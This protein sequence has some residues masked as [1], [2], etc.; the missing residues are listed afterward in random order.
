[1][2]KKV[3]IE[4]WDGK[5][6]FDPCS[7]YMY[8]QDW[9]EG[10]MLVEHKKGT[11]KDER[12]QHAWE[13]ESWTYQNNLK[14]VAKLEKLQKNI[15][16]I[17]PTHRGHRPWMK[18]CLES[19]AALGYFVILCYDNPYKLPGMDWASRMPSPDAMYAADMVLMKHVTWHAGVG[20]PHIWNVFYGVRMARAMGFEYIL[21]IN[22]DCILDQPENFPKIIEMLGDND[23][24]CCSS[25]FEKKP[26]FCGS[27]GFL[28]K[29]E[30]VDKFWTDYLLKMYH[31]NVGNAETRMGIFVKE[32][33]YKLVETAQPERGFRFPAEGNEWYEI[34]GFRHLH[35]EHKHRK[36]ERRTPLPKKYY[37]FGPNNIY[38]GKTELD[39]LTKFWETGEEQY[40]T[41]WWDL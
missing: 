38:I 36:W 1:M 10:R 18:P 33:G 15:A 19:H 8:R 25:M 34:L 22:G 32:N 35:A 28:A 29:A 13:E 24:I 2:S 30:L 23:I 31:F 21:N 20:A 26:P 37:D 7:L 6:N 27:M 12:Y 17:I 11:L 39:I 16:V 41:A 9:L 4:N 40:K 14:D 3:H 5:P